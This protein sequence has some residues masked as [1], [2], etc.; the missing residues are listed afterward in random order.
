V[1]QMRVASRRLRS[2]LSAVKSML[3][4]EQYRWLQEELKWL[5]GSLAP[6]R[7]WDV[8]ATDLLA[9]VRSALPADANL[10][11]LAEA[12]KQ[13]RQAVYDTAKEVIGSRRESGPLFN[14]SPVLSYHALRD[15]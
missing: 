6:V 10:E 14:V 2:M 11:Q 5:A 15:P 8:F 7:N 3:P 9:P 1:Q 13:R 12:A 4:V